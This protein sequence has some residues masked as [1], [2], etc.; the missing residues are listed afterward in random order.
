[1]GCDRVSSL[2]LIPADY[3][4]LVQIKYNYTLLI[5]C[6]YIL[7]YYKS[8]S[9]APKLQ[10]FYKFER[11]EFSNGSDFSTK[12]LL[13]SRGRVSQYKLKAIGSKGYG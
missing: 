5:I 8:I 10:R 13:T 9:I 6:D 1:M 2:I 7:L 4:S 11:C 12:F 3:S